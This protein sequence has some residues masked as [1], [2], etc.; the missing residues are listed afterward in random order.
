MTDTQAAQSA[1]LQARVSPQRLTVN[2]PVTVTGSAPS[3]DAGHRA[4]LQTTLSTP[5][6][7]RTVGGSRISRA[8]SFRIRAVIRHS[9]YLR[10]LVAQPLASMA[11]VTPAA[12]AAPASSRVLPVLIHAH[13]RVRPHIV[14][15]LPGQPA[16]YAGHLIP[17]RAGRLVRLQARSGA[18]WRTVGSARTGRAG[19][20]RIRAAAGGG[21]GQRLRILFAGDP[22][23]ARSIQPA[24]RLVMFTADVASWYNDA[25]STACGFHAGLGVA[26]RSLPCGTKVRFYYGGRTVTA[27]VDDRGPYV[28]GRNWD[29]NQNTAAA[30][31][32]GG[33]G[34]VWVAH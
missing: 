3:A 5:G 30:L 16:A 34:T 32:F 11:S 6:R 14:A 21:S 9:G 10:V 2:H 13:F 17:A 22:L 25:G 29:L 27:T 28:G 15:V 7:W 23:N 20:F 26:N 4:V 19:G 31:G 24:G 1:A 8:G 12:A 33:V 18:G